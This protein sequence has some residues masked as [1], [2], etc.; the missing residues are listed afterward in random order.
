MVPFTISLTK[1]NKVAHVIC[2]SFR[3]PNGDAVFVDQQR[4][5]PHLVH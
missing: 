4:G 1:M 3:F 2:A 5:S